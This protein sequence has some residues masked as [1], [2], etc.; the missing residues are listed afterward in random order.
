MRVLVMH[1]EGKPE[2]DEIIEAPFPEWVQEDGRPLVEPCFG[3]ALGEVDDSL[4]GRTKASDYEIIEREVSVPGMTPDD[5][6]EVK[7]YRFARL[8]NS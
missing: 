1:R 3:Y 2:L 5:E 7:V 4:R 8:I 6:P